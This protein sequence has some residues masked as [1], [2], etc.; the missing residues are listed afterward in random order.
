MAFAIVPN[1]GYTSIQQDGLDA[2]LYNQGGASFNMNSVTCTQGSGALTFTLNPCVLK[3]RSTTLTTGVPVER[4]L[5]TAASLV[6][7]SGGTLGAVTTVQ[8]RIVLVALDNAGTV[9]LACINIAGGNDLS[10]TGV[11]NTTAIS[12]A[13]TAN[14]VFYSTSSRTG[15]AYRVVGVVD[16]VNTAGAWASPVLVQGAGGNALTAM[17]SLGYGQ[18]YQ[19]L[20]GSRTASTTYYNTTGKPIDTQITLNAS[21]GATISCTVNGVQFYGSSQGT[22]AYYTYATFRV[23][24]GGSYSV[25]NTAGTSTVIKWIEVR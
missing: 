22:T 23:P 18:T 25:V 3:F 20:T 9:E 13:S 2:L 17:S 21:V 5:N 11:I 6:L 14:N 19:D 12:A 1:I 7:A 15:V 4:T 10:E 16:A 8:S 24:I